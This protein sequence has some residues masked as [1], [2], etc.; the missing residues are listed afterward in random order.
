MSRRRLQLARPILGFFA[1]LAFWLALGGLWQAMLAPP[2]ELLL[3][4]FESPTVTRL[5]AVDEGVRVERSDFSPRSPRPV[6]PVSDLT[7]NV[8]LLFALFAIGDTFSDRNVGRFAI[9]LA[10]LSASQAFFLFV[11]VKMIYAL[12]LGAWS[13]ANYGAVSRNVWGFLDHFYRV[14]GM[15]AI[16][17]VLWW[18]LGRRAG[19]RSN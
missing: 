18:W 10:I 17:F 16:A 3:R 9:A 15:Y 1:G 2:A 8:V 14:V 12:Q 11:R 6:V 19:A 4:I 7:F 5:E 13:A